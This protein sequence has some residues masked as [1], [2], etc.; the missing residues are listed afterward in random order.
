MNRVVHDVTSKPSGTIEQ[1]ARI[2]P[3]E[4]GGKSGTGIAIFLLRHCER[5]AFARCASY[6]RVRVRRSAERVGGSEA[7]SILPHEIASSAFGLLAMTEGA[8]PFSCRAMNAFATSRALS[9]CGP[10]SATHSCTE[11]SNR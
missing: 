6:G 10:G 7:I 5:P 11:F 4:G 1:V 2:D 3:R 8:Y 9:V